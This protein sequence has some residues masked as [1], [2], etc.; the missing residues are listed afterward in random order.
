MRKR[1]LTV[2]LA[3]VLLFMATL[4]LHAATGTYI[5]CIHGCPKL[6]VCTNCCNQVFNSVLTRCDANRD[7]CEALCP[8]GDMNCLDAC[9]MARN[10]CLMQDVRNFDCPHWGDNGRNLG[11]G[12]GTGVSVF[13]NITPKASSDSVCKECHEDDR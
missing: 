4:N 8:P 10:N 13:F 1:F 5:D 12:S 6:I 2:P 7:Q 9:I 11:I 3:L